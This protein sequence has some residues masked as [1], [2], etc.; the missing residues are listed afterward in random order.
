M[1]AKRHLGRDNALSAF[2]DHR[3]RVWMC[4]VILVLPMS[5]PLLNLFV[6]VRC[7]SKLSPICF[8]GGWRAVTVKEI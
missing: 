3:L 8:K 4:G 7:R 6:P 2:R 1:A 5:V